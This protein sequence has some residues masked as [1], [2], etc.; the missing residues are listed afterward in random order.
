ME[1]DVYKNVLQ[2]AG[3]ALPIPFLYLYYFF[4][5]KKKIPTAVNIGFQDRSR[6]FSIQVAPQLSSRG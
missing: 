6:H 4:H 1:T 5:N 3:W 2:K